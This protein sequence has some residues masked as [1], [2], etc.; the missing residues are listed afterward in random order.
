M[1]RARH[2]AFALAAAVVVC[3]LSPTKL[4]VEERASPETG[5]AAPLLLGLGAH[6]PRSRLDPDKSPW[7]AVGK[8][9]VPSIRSYQSCTA[10]LVAPL[11]VLTTAHCVFN[12]RTQRYHLRGSLHFLI[13]YDGSGYAR[14]AL[15]IKLE[16]GKGYDPT[17]PRETIGSD[18]ALIILDTTLGSPDRVLPMLSEPPEIGNRVMLGGYQQDH[19][20][21]LTADIGCRIIGWATDAGGRLLHHNCTGT[22]GVSGAPLLMERDGKWYIVGVDVAAELGVAS[23]FA[24]ALDRAHGH[25]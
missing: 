9:Q 4:E 10:T 17:R 1:A 24:V 12:P 2:Y 15:A 11:T 19:P 21:I 22:E 16:T 3:G 7:R 23:G 6:D 14:H 13:G 8:L 25:H 18:W 5:I 20:L